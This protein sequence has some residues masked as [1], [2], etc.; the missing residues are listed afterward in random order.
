MLLNIML[1]D[2]LCRV[3]TVHEVCIS[4]VL[5]GSMDLVFIEV[6]VCIDLLL[7]DDGHIVVE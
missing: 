7:L 3:N 6:C 4:I 1:K 2:Y 5:R